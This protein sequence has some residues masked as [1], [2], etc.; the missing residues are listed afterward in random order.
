MSS[1]FVTIFYAVEDV[2]GL[3]I[4]IESCRCAC[5][6]EPILASMKQYVGTPGF[7]WNWTTVGGASDGAVSSNEVPSFQRIS[8]LKLLEMGV[9]ALCTLLGGSAGVLGGTIL[10]KLV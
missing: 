2:S 9:A 5:S 3:Q 6:L 1:V 8:A 4:I 7:V 10:R